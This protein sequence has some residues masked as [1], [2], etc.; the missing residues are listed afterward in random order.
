MANLRQLGC[1]PERSE[2]K[3]VFLM[4]ASHH[5]GA[6]DIH[7]WDQEYAPIP[8]PFNASGGHLYRP[9]PWSDRSS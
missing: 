7:E 1:M 2:A 8:V 3:L 6:P 9:T 4:G 5:P